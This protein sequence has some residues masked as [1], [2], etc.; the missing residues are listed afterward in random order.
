[1]RNN[2]N[3]VISFLSMLVLALLIYVVVT[4][5]P[6]DT[7][8]L[9]DSQYDVT[10][11]IPDADEV[12][13]EEDVISEVVEEIEVVEEVEEIEIIEEVEEPSTVTTEPTTILETPN[14]PLIEEP[15]ETEVVE[16]EVIEP[17]VVE[18]EPVVE[19]P[20]E[21]EGEVINF[22]VTAYCPCYECCGKWSLN[23]PVDEN[24][25]E[26]VYGAA[27]IPL[28]DGVSCASPLPFGTEVEL[29]GYGTVVVQD[30]TAK[31]VVDKYGE[32]IIDIYVDSHD[33]IKNI[34]RQYWDGVIK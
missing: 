2:L 23:R 27:M 24:G 20:A 5:C 32:N 14:E 6:I 11:T 25:K 21:V 9:G 13:T 29:E 22:R 19:V 8:E 1:M 16:E 3:L 31:W 10:F 28:T 33:K 30:R 26:I 17:P 12:L 34:G 7:V 4:A 18:E 15:I